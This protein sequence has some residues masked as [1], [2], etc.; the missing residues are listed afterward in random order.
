MAQDPIYSQSYAAPMLI[1]PSFTGLTYGSRISMNFRDQ[2]PGAES[3]YRNYAISWDG[4]FEKFSSGFGVMINRN[5]QAQGTYVYQNISLL[6]SYDFEIARGYN[7]RPGM[8]FQYIDRALNYSKLV[9]GNQINPDNGIS[10][11]DANSTIGVAHNSKFDAAASVMGYTKNYWLGV[12]F[13]HLVKADI[14]FSDQ[15]NYNNIKTTI[16]GG[17][18]FDLRKVYSGQ[19]QQTLTF[20]FQYLNQAGFN[21]LSLGGYWFLNPLEVGLWYRG[22]PFES[23]NGYA[24]SDAVIFIF[25]VTFGKVKFAYS[26]DLSVSELSGTSGGA[27]EV[28]LVWQLGNG[29]N[30]KSKL[31]AI[32]CPGTN[33]NMFS[34]GKY[35]STKRRSTGF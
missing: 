27:N 29:I 13:D 9:F 18:K 23:V 4:F 21:Q 32:P 34:S 35:S 16:F 10:T 22:L 33:A 8:Q 7:I 26:Y 19:T 6:Y 12:S 25:G 5:D 1:S 17:S 14:G 24:N 30:S 11:P 2:W 20:A 3:A 28:S 31:R 15:G